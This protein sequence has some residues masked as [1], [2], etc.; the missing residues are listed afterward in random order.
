VFIAL[1]KSQEV[2]GQFYQ[3]G[4][5]VE[6]SDEVGQ[7]KIASGEAAASEGPAYDPTSAATSAP[8]S[9]QQP[10]RETNS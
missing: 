1:S 3:T 6:V 2:E 10:A 8:H 4:A 7:A 9:P 5:I